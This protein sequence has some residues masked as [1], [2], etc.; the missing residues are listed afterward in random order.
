MFIAAMDGAISNGWQCTALALT[1]FG[2]SEPSDVKL[3][4][5]VSDW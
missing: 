3:A 5:K 1:A 2:Q 4:G